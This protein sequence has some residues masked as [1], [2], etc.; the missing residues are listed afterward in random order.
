[1]RSWTIE[2]ASWHDD[3]R[4]VDSNGAKVMGGIAIA[5]AVKERTIMIKRILL[6]YDGSENAE[7]ALTFA[8]DLA[9][10]YLAELHVLA[11]VQP[12]DF[13]IEIGIEAL[14]E[15]AQKHCERLID[16]VGEKLRKESI[17][18]VSHIETGGAG[19]QIVRY[20]KEHQIDHVVVG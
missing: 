18:V 8:I 6:G 14:M 7:R 11:V 10:R 12:P 19:E 3:R 20:A 2:I 16:A 15:G 17:S 13:A 4:S 9:Q 1:Q 5:A